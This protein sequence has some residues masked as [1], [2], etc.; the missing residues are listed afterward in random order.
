MTLS[1]FLQVSTQPLLPLEDVDTAA[2]RALLGR[3]LIDLALLLG[4]VR[5]GRRRPPFHHHRC[6]DNDEFMALTGL[7]EGDDA[8]PDEREEEDEDPRGRFQSAERLLSGSS[9]G[10]RNW[11][12]SP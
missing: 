9:S 11:R 5:T 7:A 1:H 12:K 2:Y 3:W 4:W 6:W 8:E 10:A